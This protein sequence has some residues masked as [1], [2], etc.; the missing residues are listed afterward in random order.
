MTETTESPGNALVEVTEI[1]ASQPLVKRDDKGRF[2]KGFSGNPAGKPKGIKHRS[3]QIKQLIDAS[4]ADMLLDEFIPV[5]E[6]AIKLAKQGDRQMIKFVLGD[7]LNEVR[8]HNEEGKKRGDSYTQVI[9]E[10]LTL[11][12]LK[13][14][15]E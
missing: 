3:T 14:K 2:V 8:K 7:L 15:Q 10:N 4:L 1:D 12:Q 13:E 6:E 11:D 5:M 9:I